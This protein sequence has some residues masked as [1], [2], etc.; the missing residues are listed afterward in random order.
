MTVDTEAG[1]GALWDVLNQSGGKEG[2]FCGNA[3]WQTRALLDRLVGQRLAK[4]RPAHAHL[5]VND[6]VDSWRVIIADPQE[7]L[8]LLFGMKAPGLGRLSFTLTDKGQ[9]RLLDVR[10]WWHPH[11]MPGLIYWLLMFPPHLFIFR[12]MA[13]RIARLAEQY[14]EKS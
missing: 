11:G 14:T 1:L 3:L 8:A 12:G 13:R 6:R 10:A 2:Y 9:Y 5:Q 4:G 7:Q